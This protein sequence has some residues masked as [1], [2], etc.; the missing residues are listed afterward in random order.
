MGENKKKGKK[1]KGNQT[2]HSASI[3]TAEDVNQTKP[4]DSMQNHHI[5]APSN[6][7]SQSVGVS[8]SDLDQEKR[9]NC[10]EK[11]VELLEEINKLEVEKNICSQKENLHGFLEERIKLLQN[12]VNSFIQ[13][14]ASLEEQIDD[15][16]CK[17]A[18][19]TMRE[20]D[21]EERVKK[22]E[23]WHQSF[24]LEESSIKEVVSKL[25]DANERLHSQ[26]MELQDSRDKLAQENKQLT[27]SISTL[28]SRIQHLEMVASFNVSSKI[29]GQEKPH[30][31]A[32]EAS[33]KPN[34][35]NEDPSEKAS[36]IHVEPVPVQ[37]DGP[38]ENSTSEKTINHSSTMK[39]STSTASEYNKSLL[40]S[41]EKIETFTKTNESCSVNGIEDLSSM[42]QLQQV[43]LLGLN[44]SRESED[45]ISVPLD[46]IIQE[47]QATPEKS[48]AEPVVPFSD[49]PLI[50]APFRLISFVARFVSGADL[51]DQDKPKRDF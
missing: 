49:A 13:K 26:V 21:F 30:L 34:I 7:D 23:E 47:L 38:A 3:F 50:G 25:D 39:S 41:N 15:L 35:L 42:E 31:K 14:E 22:M 2:K 48:E 1:K 4:D 11:C 9:S 8:E 36:E 43:Q 6:A 33:T 44:D 28:E 18:S 27:D 17:N 16:Q 19:L 12:E 40:E 29:H 45:V 51:V 46:D 24:A 32:A 10:E 37:L 5:G 20:A